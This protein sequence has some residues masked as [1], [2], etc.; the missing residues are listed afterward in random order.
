MKVK[1]L[2]LLIVIAKKTRISRRYESFTKVKGEVLNKTTFEK[3]VA[4]RVVQR[5]VV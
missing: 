3:R 5:G 1:R 4:N 2:A